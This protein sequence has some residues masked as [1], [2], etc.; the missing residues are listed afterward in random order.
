MYDCGD[1]SDEGRV[2][3]QSESQEGEIDGV[4]FL[5]WV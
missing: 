5:E 3:N 1:G 2:C 4:I